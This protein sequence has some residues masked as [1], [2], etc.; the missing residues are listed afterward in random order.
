MKNKNSFIPTW[1]FLFLATALFFMACQKREFMPDPEGVRVPYPDTITSSIDE[2][3]RRGTDL[4]VFYAAWEKSSI[5]TIM[6]AKGTNTRFTVFAPTDAALQAKGISLASIQEMTVPYV[7]SLLLFYVAIGDITP[8]TLLERP[9]NLMV[10]SLLPKPAVYVNYYEGNA[11]TTMQYDL[12]YYRFYIKAQGDDIFVNGKKNGQLKYTPATNGAVYTMSMMIEKPTKTALEVL[13][14]DGRFTLFVESQR[15]TDQLFLQTIAPVLEPYLG[16]IPDDI[17]MMTQ[18]AYNRLY[19]TQ[20][21][22][23]ERPLYEGFVGPNISISTTFAPTDEAFRKAGFNTV[24]DIIKF[25]KE[26]G[27]AR[28]DEDYFEIKGGYP[29]DTLF[30]YHRNWGRIMQPQ[31]LGLDK[32]RSNNTV[33]FIHDLGPRLNEYMVNIG[34]VPAEFNYKMPL[35]FSINNGRVEIKVKGSDAVPASVID[36]DIMSFNGPIHVV[37]NLLVPKGL[38]LK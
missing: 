15:L 33:F 16:Y 27:D 25:N 5:Q 6:K 14:E 19:Y 36:G 2:V 1:G 11:G 26:N 30:S 7:D 35:A 29:T 10:K 31:T 37:D 3:L 9:D 22:G 18:W 8:P 4:K 38:K 32:A 24:A 28:F 13:E 34:G 12:Y 23:F 21:W 20:S 17:E